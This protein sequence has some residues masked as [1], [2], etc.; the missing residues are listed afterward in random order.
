[1]KTLDFKF[2]KY[3]IPI[4]GMGYLIWYG[5]MTVFKGY[6]E[7]L[8]R[9]GHNL[10]PFAYLGFILYASVHVY[11]TALLIAWILSLTGVI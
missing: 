7:N 11:G 9:K 6:G 4:F 5:I 1:M 2:W 3:F 8:N 10:N